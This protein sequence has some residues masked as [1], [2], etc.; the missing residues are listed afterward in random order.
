[1]EEGAPMTVQDRLVAHEL[2][3]EIRS[4]THDDA[5]RDA[6]LRAGARRDHRQVN[7]DVYS[8]IRSEILRAM[9]ADA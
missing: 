3:E 4:M 9:T 8:E 6:L 2:A 5:L 1:M 7:P